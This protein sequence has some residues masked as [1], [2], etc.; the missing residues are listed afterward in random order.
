M[1]DPTSEQPPSYKPPRYIRSDQNPFEISVDLMRQSLAIIYHHQH[2]RDYIPTEYDMQALYNLCG[3]ASHIKNDIVKACQQIE[4][5]FY[6]TPTTII[7]GD[8]G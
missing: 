1:T 5:R 3:L 2:R 7:Q 8:D 4:Q 6:N